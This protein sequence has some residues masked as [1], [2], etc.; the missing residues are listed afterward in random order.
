MKKTGISRRNFIRDA[1]ITTGMASI[2]SLGISGNINPVERAPSSNHEVWIAGIS[3]MW[4]RTDT[5]ESM[6]EIIL[7]KLKEVVAFRPD[8]VCLPELFPFQNISKDYSLKEMLEISGNVLE[9]FSAFSKKNQCYTVCPV[10]TAA[11]GKIYNSSV[12]LNRQ[13]KR[14]GV[15]NK[16]HPTESEIEM[17]IASGA[18]FQPVIETE[19]GPVGAQICFDINWNDGWAMLQKQNPKIV[20]WP[21][22]YDGGK[23][24]NSKAWTHQFII[25]TATNQNNSKLCDVTGDIIAQ[26]G[27]WNKYAFC[28]PVN[29]EKSFIHVW[30]YSKR[31]PD[32]EKKYGRKI[33]IS[34]YH[35]EQ[36]AIIESLSPEIFVKDILREFEIRTMADH[37]SSGEIAQHKAR[38]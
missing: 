12:F 10:Y 14:I 29:L 4:I 34:I 7:E 18:L 23:M 6:T 15:Y 33:K 24:I 27:I 35:E 36:W 19:Y 20:F 25:A 31:F 32:I 13:G 22:A 37:I 2:S 26:T 9:Q 28:A 11:D 16:I 1:A 5:A 30:P 21:S 38:T 17:G 3:Q 8:F